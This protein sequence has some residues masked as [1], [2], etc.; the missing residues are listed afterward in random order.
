[1]REDNPYWCSSIF[2]FCQCIEIML[3]GR[4]IT[5]TLPYILKLKDQIE[6]FVRAG[7]NI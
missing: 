4:G 3:G 1:M 7:T 6:A 2:H 5:T